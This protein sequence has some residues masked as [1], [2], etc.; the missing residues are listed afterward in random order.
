MSNNHA[1]YKKQN[2]KIWNEIA[3]RY[4]KRWAGVNTGPWKS[5]SKIIEMSGA[6]NGDMVLDLACGTGIVSSKISNKVGKR[7]LVIGLD[8][9]IKA[10][11]IAKRLNFSKENI[12]FVNCDAEKFGLKKKFDIITCQYALFFF[13]NSKKSIKKC[14]KKF[15][16]KWNYHFSMFMAIIRH[17]FSSIVNSVTKF[18]PDYLPV[19][20]AKL[21]RFGTIP[22]LRQ[23]MQ[24][25]GLRNVRIKEFNFS[26]S[27]GTFEDYWRNYTK[28]VAKSIKEKL[29]ELNKQERNMIRKEIKEN[30]IKFTRKDGRI[31]F[32]WQVLISTANPPK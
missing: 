14:N 10:I 18:I 17:N 9:S 32:P 31:V 8:T 23:E 27:P 1:V 22:E 21:D 29:N 30:T 5:T 4:H 7:G 11:E 19:G 20:S 12:H 24:G 2:M 28:Y 13:P 6:K 25:A 16:K 26:F 15:E 3:P